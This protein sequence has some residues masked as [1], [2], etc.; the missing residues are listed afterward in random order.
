MVIYGGTLISGMGDEPVERGVIVID[1]NRIASV[2]SITHEQLVELS[3]A[4]FMADGA[5][6]PM[7]IDAVGKYVMPGLIDGHCHL[8][9]TQGALPGVHY[10]SSAEFATLWA[11]R[12]AGRALSAGVTSISVPG[13]KWFADVTVR[14]AID[15]GL[16]QGPRIFAAGRALTPYGGIF[17]PSSYAGDEFADGA[18][19]LCNS[20]DEYVRE[21]RW[22]AKHNVDLIKVADSYWGDTQVISLDELKMVVD[23]AHRRNLAVAIHA[24]GGGST[25]DAALAGVDWIFH[26]DLANDEDL[27]VVAS[28][29]TPIMPTFTSVFLGNEHPERLGMSTKE[30]DRYRRQYD[31]SLETLREARSRGIPILVGTDAGN[32]AAFGHGEYHGYEAEILVRELGF[33]P[34]DAIVANTRLNAQV[35]RMDSEIGVVEAGRLADLLILKE[36]PLDDISVLHRPEAISAVIKD[37]EVVDRGSEGFRHLEREPEKAR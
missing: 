11:A 14:E 4:D 10:R 28:T 12:A 5:E 26:A 17:D 36:D 13:G 3:A 27:D 25:K 37:G 35:M 21:V 32:T 18:G 33:T 16:I 22:Q 7:L 6:E 24:R 34:M 19:V 8:S 29:G 1:G 23:E 9:L 15:G 2:S 31:T 30:L 20:P